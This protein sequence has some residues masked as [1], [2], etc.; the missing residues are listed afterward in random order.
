MKIWLFSVIQ[1]G[2]DEPIT[3]AA[4]F[5]KLNYSELSMFDSV[6]IKSEEKERAQKM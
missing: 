3:L 6:S 4:Q 5:R 1:A 2:L